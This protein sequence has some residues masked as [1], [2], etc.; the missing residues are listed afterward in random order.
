VLTGAT[1]RVVPFAG[2]EVVVTG[3]YL[4]RGVFRVDRVTLAPSSVIATSALAR[5]MR[6]QTDS[7]G[8]N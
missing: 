8:K 4:S 6:P 7:G 3:R 2:L 5:R 1:D